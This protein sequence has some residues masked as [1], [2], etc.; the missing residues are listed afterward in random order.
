MKL[1]DKYLFNILVDIHLRER[2]ILTFYLEWRVLFSGSGRIHIAA[3]RNTH[4]MQIVYE[5]HEWIAF[6]NQ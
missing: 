2:Y 6:I 3:F 1:I 4:R 5:L